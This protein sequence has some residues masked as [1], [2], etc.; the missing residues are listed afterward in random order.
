MRACV[1][2]IGVLLV[3]SAASGASL[4]TVPKGNLVQDPG[5]ELAVPAHDGGFAV[6]PIPGWQTDSKFT[7]IAY[8]DTNVPTAAEAA[9]WHGEKVFF[10]GGA[11]NALAHA[12][13]TIDVSSAAAEIDAGRLTATLAAALGGYS[14]QDDYATVTAIARDAG[15]RQL[16][17]VT[18][19]PVKAADRGGVTKLVPRSATA[20]IPARTHSIDIVLTATRMSGAYNDGYLDSVSLTIG[21]AKGD[22]TP[23]KVTALPSSGKAK[24]WIKLRHTMTDDSGTARAEYRVYRGSS[25]RSKHMGD[26]LTVKAGAVY[27]VTYRTSAVG[28]LK[29]CVQAWDKAGNA[30]KLS[31]ASLTISRR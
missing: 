11:D 9:A 6:I 14:G 28:N 5:A 2:A 15:G 31:C 16:G 24:T 29:F 30:S 3:L 26:W 1:L 25:L 20:P 17:A 18:V 7:A 10:A 22:R 27:G 23:P 12:R 8:G 13:Q 21:V 4:S 19:G